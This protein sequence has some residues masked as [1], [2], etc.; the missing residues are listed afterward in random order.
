M[1]MPRRNAMVCLPTS[2]SMSI[3]LPA[4]RSCTVRDMGQIVS[5]LLAR[6]DQAGWWTPAGGGAPPGTCDGRERLP[7]AGHSSAGTR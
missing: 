3:D 6:Y 7:L 2:E 4:E 5:Q 1:W